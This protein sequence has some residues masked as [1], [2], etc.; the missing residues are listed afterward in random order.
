MIAPIKTP[1]SPNRKNAQGASTR[2]DEALIDCH[3]ATDWP[4]LIA[5]QLTLKTK[6]FSSR[7]SASAPDPALSFGGTAVYTAVKVLPAVSVAG[8][9]FSGLRPKPVGG[10][11]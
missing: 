1:S 8:G 7:L 4:L 6:I 3:A 10:R 9:G 5:C 2:D 11:G